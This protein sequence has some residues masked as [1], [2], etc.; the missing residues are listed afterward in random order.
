MKLSFVLALVLALPVAL[1][2]QSIHGRVVDASSGEAVPE[3]SVIVTGGDQRQPVRAQ[4]RADGGFS[5]ALRGPGS[6]R[7]RVERTGYAPATSQEVAMEAGEVVQVELKIST[8]PVTL[9][10]LTVIG[11]QAAPRV[12]SLETSGFYDR[13][14]RG[15]GRFM[16]RD[17]FEKRRGNRL[18][19]ILDEVPGI[20]LFRDRSGNQYVTF[21]RAQSNGA[22]SRAQTGQANLCQPIFFLDGSRVSAGSPNSGG[23][24]LNDLVEPERI[25]AM[26][27]YASVAQLPVEFN[28][29]D[30][31][32]GVIVIW[33]RKGP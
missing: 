3:A 10:P 28:A 18:I 16:K 32:C 8:Q 24:T 27:V 13:E 9:A 7:V 25:E 22:F 31:S 19:N 17:H 21:T 20:Q 23:V 15:H 26:E 29:S 4:T 12:A 11:R 33:T 14:K 2:A 6:Y 30:A 1:D 5:L